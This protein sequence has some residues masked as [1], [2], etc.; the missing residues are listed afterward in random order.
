M[1]VQ[2]EDSC[3]ERSECS[4][5]HRDLRSIQLGWRHPSM[6]LNSK[7]LSTKQRSTVIPF[8]YSWD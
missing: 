8:N 6:E 4:F 5:R 7:K 2:T 3:F 1:N